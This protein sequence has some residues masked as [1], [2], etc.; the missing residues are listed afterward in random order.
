MISYS[1]DEQLKR[2]LKEVIKSKKGYRTVHGVVTLKGTDSL[3]QIYGERMISINGEI[4][5][6]HTYDDGTC[7]W[8]CRFEGNAAPTGTDTL[9]NP[10][11]IV[12]FPIN[13]NW[14]SRQIAR[15]MA[16][17]LGIVF[18]FEI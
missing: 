13:G 12:E 10:A 1:F 2:E 11:T 5:P 3:T 16:L 6:D 15:S 17:N 8:T 9:I 14:D 4:K 7:K 18:G